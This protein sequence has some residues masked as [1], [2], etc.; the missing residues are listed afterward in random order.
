MFFLFSSK[1][2]QLRAVLAERA[3]KVQPRGVISAGEGVQSMEQFEHAD[4]ARYYLLAVRVEITIARYRTKINRK[5]YF[6]FV[7]FL[8]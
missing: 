2:N 6:Y 1:S 7:S 4:Q 8:S 3:E 5:F